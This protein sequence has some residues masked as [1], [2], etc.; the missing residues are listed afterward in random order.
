[1][2]NVF[3]LILALML[4]LTSCQKDEQ[5]TQVN[6]IQ[7]PTEDSLI[8]DQP[9]DDE[10]VDDEPVDEFDPNHRNVVIL[11]NYGTGPNQS[12]YHFDKIIYINDVP[13]YYTD[14]TIFDFDLNVGDVVR[15]TM[16]LDVPAEISYNDMV[17]ISVRTT[18]DNGNQVINATNWFYNDCD[19][20][21]LY[22][23][24]IER[25]ITIF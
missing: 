4:I 3:Y 16:S 18:D 19:C 8:I 14:G 20:S 15:F 22:E 24:N 23:W 9:V 5:I 10:P 1:M 7:T 2:K 12:I 11:V 21:G 17:R 13:H 25:T 6:D